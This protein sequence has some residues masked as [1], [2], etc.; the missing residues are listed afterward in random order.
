MT[1]EGGRG[2]GGRQ[3]AP[4]KF[5]YSNQFMTGRVRQKLYL[6]LKSDVSRVLM[7]PFLFLAK[8][9]GTGNRH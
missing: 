9:K 5:H 7:A 8:V 2:G 1:G 4:M 6:P 3:V